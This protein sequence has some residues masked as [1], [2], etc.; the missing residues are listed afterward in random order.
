MKPILNDIYM[1][2]L[3]ANELAAIYGGTTEPKLI[4]VPLYL[5]LKL[6]EYLS[7]LYKV[8]FNR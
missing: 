2:E 6:G 5:G 4:I 1:A 7:D 8:Y 3:S